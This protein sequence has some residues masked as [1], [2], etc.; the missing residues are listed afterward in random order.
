MDKARDGIVQLDGN[1]AAGLLGELFA[2]DLTVATLTCGGCGADAAV[3]EARVYGGSMGA[4]FRC[5]ACDA[6]VLRVTRTPRGIWL[7]MRGA[8]CLHVRPEP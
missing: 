8:R 6:A 7:D 4:I 1:A 3:G 5:G 2:V